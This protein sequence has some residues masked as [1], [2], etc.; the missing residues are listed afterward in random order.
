MVSLHP[1]GVTGVGTAPAWSH[2]THSEWCP[3]PRKSQPIPV[4]FIWDAGRQPAAS[5]GVR[6][7]WEQS[8]P[9]F[10]LFSPPPVSVE[11][12]QDAPG[13]T[14]AAPQ[15]YRITNTTSLDTSGVSKRITKPPLNGILCPGKRHGKGF[16]SLSASSSSTQ[17][18]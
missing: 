8:E 10:G 15:P 4:G 16:C 5:V 1:K 18:K 14:G 2:P 13:P 12:Q 3:P 11:A 7:L 9:Q 6:A 17:G